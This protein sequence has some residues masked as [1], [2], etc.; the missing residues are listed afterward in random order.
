VN[1]RSDTNNPEF[2]AQNRINPSVFGFTAR[3]G[4][5]VPPIA[6]VTGEK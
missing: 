2:G 5:S 4:P 6:D 1:S 3:R